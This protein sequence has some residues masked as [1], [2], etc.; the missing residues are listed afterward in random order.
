MILTDG[1][2][3]VTDGEM[4]EL[5]AFASEIGCKRNWF[6]NHPQCPHYVIWGARLKKAFEKGA[7]RVSAKNLI[8]VVRGEISAS[9][10]TA[11]SYKR[12]VLTFGDSL[13]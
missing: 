3:L 10:A 7:K 11:S 9:Q 4:E 12:K 8:K 5:H 2:H 6:Q 13:D 1:I